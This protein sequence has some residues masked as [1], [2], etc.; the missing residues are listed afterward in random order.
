MPS[1]KLHYIKKVFLKRVFVRRQFTLIECHWLWS[2]TAEIFPLLNLLKANLPIGKA[3][4]NVMIVCHLLL[5]LIKVRF[6][7][8]AIHV[9]HGATA[10]SESTNLN[11]LPDIWVCPTFQ[12]SHFSRSKDGRLI[13]KGD[14]SNCADVLHENLMTQ[15]EFFF[16]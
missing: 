10:E 5:R 4:Q 8:S 1:Q 3:T 16:C 2:H 13:R 11:Q 14:Y 15:E 9:K 12:L 7:I 6:F